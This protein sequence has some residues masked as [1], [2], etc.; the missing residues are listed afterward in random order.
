[1]IVSLSSAAFEKQGLGSNI[2]REV[3]VSSGKK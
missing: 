3:G 1:M 2:I